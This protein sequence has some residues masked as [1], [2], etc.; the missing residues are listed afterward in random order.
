MG[1]PPKLMAI[2]AAMVA[3]VTGHALAQQEPAS[4]IP[5]RI[6]VEGPS[7]MPPAPVGHRQPR[8]SDLPPDLAREQR[9]GLSKPTESGEPTATGSTR[10]KPN[11]PSRGMIDEWLRICRG[12]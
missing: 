1:A 5:P 10:G 4:P 7:V 8:L 11:T 6:F 12:C 3:M 9:S 2:T